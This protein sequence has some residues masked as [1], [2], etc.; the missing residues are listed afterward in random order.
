M[1]LFSIEL[2][3]TITNEQIQL[4]EQLNFKVKLKSKA[5]MLSLVAGCNHENN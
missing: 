4:N 1:Q 2:A 3:R 5:S